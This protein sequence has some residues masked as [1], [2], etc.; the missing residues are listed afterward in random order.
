MEEE[1]EE[2]EEAQMTKDGERRWN[3]SCLQA[4]SNVS[5]HCSFFFFFCLFWLLP[6]TEYF[7]GTYCDHS[8][9]AGESNY[10]R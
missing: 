8:S 5:K 4:P 9:D 2:D 1:E 7:T 3:S 6:I 10:E